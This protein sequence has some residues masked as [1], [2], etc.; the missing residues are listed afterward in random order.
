MLRSNEQILLKIGSRIRE[1]RI[2]LKLSQDQLA[3]EAGLR[4]ETINKI[5]SGKINISIVKLLKIIQVL[6]CTISEI[7]PASL[8]AT[9]G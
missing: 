4:R 7:L 6:N 9:E 5:E 1:K 2:E 3:F 8:V